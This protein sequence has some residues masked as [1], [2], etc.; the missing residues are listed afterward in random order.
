MRQALV[1]IRETHGKKRDSLSRGTQGGG[2]TSFATV[3]LRH[4]TT[5]GQHKAYET[6]HTVLMI[7]QA[8][9]C[10]YLPSSH[11]AGTAE[12]PTAGEFG[13]DRNACME[14]VYRA[15][16]LCNYLH[17]NEAFKIFSVTLRNNRQF[18]LGSWILSGGIGGAWEHQS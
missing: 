18:F 11:V 12:N 15:S 2:T 1:D 8:T 3:E 7:L 14:D 10:Q 17:R 9:R 13:W 5:D 16:G 6:Q 4:T